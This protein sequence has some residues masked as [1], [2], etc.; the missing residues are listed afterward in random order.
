MPNAVI[1]GATQGIGKAIAEKFLSEGFDIV[2]CARN[3]QDLDTIKTSWAKQYPQR[4]VLVTPTDV[5][6]K[7]GAFAFADVVLQSFTTIDVLVNNAGTYYPGSLADEPDGQLEMLMNLN[8]FSAYHITR[9]LLPAMKKQQQGHI[10]NMCS[11]AS[12]KAYPNG[13]AYSITKYAM[14]GFSEN[15]REELKNDLIKVTSVSPG[16][17]YSR[18]WDGSGVPQERIMQAADI[19]DMVWAAYNLSPQA[20]VETI[21]IRPQLGDL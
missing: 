10:F 17:V 3:A 20:C 9:R 12:H 15:L 14:L 13:G 21:L 11:V 6:T 7:E 4:M 1:T 2:I 8:L 5:A 19:A 16:A 18:S